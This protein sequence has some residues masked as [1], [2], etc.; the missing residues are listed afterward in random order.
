[1]LVHYHLNGVSCKFLLKRQRIFGT[2]KVFGRQYGPKEEFNGLKMSVG[3]S[4]S[5]HNFIP[6][7]RT[8]SFRVY[9]YL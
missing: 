7:E 2:Q 9:T 1:M 5:R 4:T 6:Q 8:T 3:L